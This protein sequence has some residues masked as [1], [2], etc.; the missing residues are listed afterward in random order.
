MKALLYGVLRF[1]AGLG[2]FVGSILAFLFYAVAG[3]FF[4]WLLSNFALAFIDWEWVTNE[5]V[6]QLFGYLFI[7]YRHISEV[8]VAG[9]IGLLGVARRLMGD[10]K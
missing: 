2:L 3:Y 5:Y 9:M 10:G 8:V 4:Y 7:E 6:I 1:L